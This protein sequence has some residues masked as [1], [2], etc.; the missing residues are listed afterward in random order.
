[1]GGGH[2]TRPEFGLGQPD[3]R[4]PMTEFYTLLL[5]GLAG[6]E[7]FALPGLYARFDPPAWPIEPEEA[8]DWCALSPAPRA[9]YACVAEPGR[10]RPLCAELRCTP[11]GVP[12]A[13]VLT[14]E[15]SR[16]GCAV[17]LLPPWPLPAEEAA[18][19]WPDCALALTL[20]MQPADLDLAD[21]DPRALARQWIAGLA[22]KAWARHPLLDRWL[23]AQAARW[24]RL[25][26]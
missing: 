20:A 18:P 23:A 16:A 25:W 5:D 15:G 24:Q 21:A 1:M 17:R 7:S 12:A 19:P 9:G 3:P 14:Q 22:G 26:R 6:A 4:C 8:P 11:A 10:L 13:L 2:L